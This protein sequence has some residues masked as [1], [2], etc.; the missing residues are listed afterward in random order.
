MNP[1]NPHTQIENLLNIIDHLTINCTNNFAIPDKYYNKPD[2]VEPPPPQYLKNLVDKLDELHKIER[3]DGNSNP[4][5]G[6]HGGVSIQKCVWQ[7]IISRHDPI[8]SK[9]NILD[10]LYK[11]YPRIFTRLAA[12]LGLLNDPLVN[13]PRRKNRLSYMV[14]STANWEMVPI[15]PNTTP[16][17]IY[18]KGMGSI[19][20]KDNMMTNQEF[21]NISNKTGQQNIIKYLKTILRNI[22]NFHRVKKIKFDEKNTFKLNLSISRFTFKELVE[23]IKHI[24]TILTFEDVSVYTK[25]DAG[26]STEIERLFNQSNGVHT[27]SLLMDYI[28]IIYK[29]KTEEEKL[30]SYHQLP[31]VSHAY[32][33][34]HLLSLLAYK[35]DGKNKASEIDIFQILDEMEQKNF[36]YLQTLFKTKLMHVLDI[37][38]ENE[39]VNKYLKATYPDLIP[40][41]KMLNNNY[42]PLLI[43]A[44]SLLYDKPTFVLERGILMPRCNIDI[45]T[46]QSASDKQTLQNYFKFEVRNGNQPEIDKNIENFYKLRNIKQLFKDI[47][48]SITNVTDFNFMRYNLKPLAF[49][50]VEEYYAFIDDIGKIFI[51]KLTTKMK[52]KIVGSSTTFYS[53][54]PMKKKDFYYNEN[55]DIDIGVVLDIDEKELNKFTKKTFEDKYG[56]NQHTNPEILLNEKLTD[57]IVKFYSKWGPND[58]IHRDV[59]SDKFAQ[60]DA[61]NERKTQFKKENT[62]LER[63]IGMVLYKDKYD[64]IFTDPAF[65]ENTTCSTN[66]LHIIPKEVA[67]VVTK[68]VKEEEKEEE[69]EWNEYSDDETGEP[70]YFNISTKETTWD[71]PTKGIIKKISAKKKVASITELNM[72]I[73]KSISGPVKFFY[74]K[75]KS[76]IDPIIIMFGYDSTNNKTLCTPCDP[77]DKPNCCYKISDYNFLELLNNLENISFIVE[78]KE[79]ESY[80]FLKDLEENIKIATTNKS[81]IN[82]VTTTNISTVTKYDNILK[83]SLVLFLMDYN[84]IASYIN[85]LQKWYIVEHHT[86]SIE[87]RCLKF[88][89]FVDI[90]QDV[91]EKNTKLKQLI[92]SGKIDGPATDHNSFSLS[93]SWSGGYNNKWFHH[94]F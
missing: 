69:V 93:K 2:V 58:W 23:I 62:I 76:D 77:N 38:F 84:R 45:I 43:Y 81:K 86:A 44:E 27:T 9:T 31:M 5:V 39:K 3:N 46:E 16:K 60:L 63:N 14:Y 34:R 83:K 71:K 57:D 33:G 29:S 30:F 49:K 12:T 73:I 70:Y 20:Q 1:L 51:P 21:R 88:P 19:N 50:T 18:I 4:S 87:N 22:I 35:A 79:K 36:F 56:L 24:F 32:D 48:D 72:T 37:I 54:N 40:D 61:I 59:S 6:W 82:F 42:E 26:G 89:F 85:Y 68:V 91:I 52:I 78:K 94:C 92:E 28:N 25:G 80:Q 11:H 17:S 8:Q 67:T 7:E 64:A 74:L 15:M 65:I 90:S 13:K 10:D 47:N 55:S 66:F 53:N 75:P 41:V